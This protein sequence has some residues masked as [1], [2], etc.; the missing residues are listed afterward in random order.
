MDRPISTDGPFLAYKPT[1]N[2]KLPV[3]TKVSIV[4]WGD[5]NP[6]ENSERTYNLRKLLKGDLRVL[7][8]RECQGVMTTFTSRNVNDEIMLCA[9][10][11]NTDSCAGD[12]GGP[13]IAT[14]DSSSQGD[15]SRDFQAGVVSW[16]PGQACVSNQTRFPGVYT[17]VSAYTEWIDSIVNAATPSSSTPLPFLQTI[18]TP[19]IIVNDLQVGIDVQFTPEKQQQVCITQGGCEC[20]PSWSY[21]EIAAYNCDNPDNDAVG[22]WC[23][24]E[25]NGG[26]QPLSVVSR[27]GELWDRCSCPTD[28]IAIAKS[29]NSK[30]VALSQLCNDTV[31]GCSC[32]DTWSYGGQDYY[33]CNN[34]DFDPLGGWCK[35]NQTSCDRPLLIDDNKNKGFDYD[36]CKQGCSAQS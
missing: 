33:G 11:R 4:G 27:T 19:S 24:V 2:N 30:E 16:G 17:R 9:Y 15:Y 32:Q 7:S 34:P 3:D 12:S 6:E 1:S 20:K 14:D 26:C 29:S 5:I 28:N 25:S 21:N 36:Y 18:D 35:V 8:W 10:S 23:I 13:L 22:S 31:V